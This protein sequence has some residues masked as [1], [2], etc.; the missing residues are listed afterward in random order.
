[1]RKYRDD[2]DDKRKVKQKVVELRRGRA[3]GIM[4][5]SY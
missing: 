1:M 2:D 5:D 4:L 3:R